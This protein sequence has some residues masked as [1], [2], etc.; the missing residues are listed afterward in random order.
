[1]I[2]LDTS[3]ALKTLILEPESSRVRAL[4]ASGVGLVSSRL[5]AV[6]L[7]AVAD[8]RRLSAAAVRELL[9]HVAIVSIDDEVARRAIDIRSG[10]RTLDALHLAT[11]VVL[12]D[13]VTGFLSFDDELNRAAEVRGFR[14]H[15]LPAD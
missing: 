10:L 4:F 3:A 12:D 11:A 5:L 8:R 7:H 13:A 2:Y 15:D 6:E 1:M 14:L 9:D